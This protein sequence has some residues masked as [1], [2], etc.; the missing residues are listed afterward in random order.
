MIRS[1]IKNLSIDIYNYCNHKIVSLLNRSHYFNPIE[2]AMYFRNGIVAGIKFK[3]FV[4]LIVFLFILP[5]VK[6]GRLFAQQNSGK[7]SKAEEDPLKNTKKL[8]RDGH[9][10]L[11]EN[12][13]FPVGSTSIKFIPPGKEAEIFI[14]GRRFGFAKASFQESLKK[15]SESVVILKEGHGLSYRLANESSKASIELSKDLRDSMILPGYYVMSKAQADVLGIGGKSWS[16]GL[17]N[18][19]SIQS[20]A[21][22]MS[23][24]LFESG[25]DLSQATIE[26]ENKRRSEKELARIREQ[27][28]K[29]REAKILEQKIQEETGRFVIGYTDLGSKL[30]ERSEKLTE[31]LGNVSTKKDFEEWEKL[32]RKF[33]SEVLDGIA[34]SWIGIG[35]RV[36]TGFRKA[37]S[38]LEK[39]ESGAGLS[40]AVLKA[41]AI[42]TKTILVD[43][44]ILP[45]GETTVHSF[46]YV[47]WNSIAYPIGLVTISGKTVAVVLV[48]VVE[49]GTD[50]VVAI[51]APSG[52]F[53]LAGIIGGS[54]VL[55]KG[56]GKVTKN[57]LDT[58]GNISSGASKRVGVASL[59]GAGVITEASGKYLVAPV[60]LGIGIGEETLVGLGS[61][62]IDTG[63]G[64][65]MA[66]T[67]SVLSVT[68]LGAGQATA[69]A[70]YVGGTTVSAGTAGAFGVYYVSKAVGVP[71]GVYIGS[72]VV[73]SYEM[74]AQL[75]AHTVLAASDMT[76]LVLSLEGGRWVLYGVKQT[77]KK[78]V[79]VLTGS[80]VDLDEIR[81]QG[82]EVYE[83]PVSEEEMEK[84]LKEVD[85]DADR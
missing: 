83:I 12:G 70:V 11:Y 52:R 65:A 51:V 34:D 45:I 68:S 16:K 43:A 27:K 82:G 40:W 8:V 44:I 30:K 55:A 84:V 62:T 23:Y 61:Y 53:A 66:T 71:T 63:S 24:I 69:G 46:G 77:G 17:H 4:S 48:E 21:E 73:M 42:T 28:K 64:A 79:Y 14:Q 15:A 59:Y 33:S 6:V 85:R 1:K 31:D 3:I 76:Y 7:E 18:Y 56:V 60:G 41:I 5:D 67:G 38:E 2:D 75:S 29:R 72:G 80:M 47:V 54:E 35:E 25:V 78:A 19:R 39:V 22:R 74:T 32:R 81:N 58:T 57:T 26:E 50:G 37:G 20:E 36:K 13:A 9:V 49:Y 10:S